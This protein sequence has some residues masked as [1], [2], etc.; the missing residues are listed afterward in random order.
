VSRYTDALNAREVLEYVVVD[1]IELSHL[2]VRAQRDSWQ[3][4]C[5]SWLLANPDDGG[6][7]RRVIERIAADPAVEGRA[8]EQRDRW[9]RWC[10][11]SLVAHPVPDLEP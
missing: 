1:C 4:T 10:A 5:R 2:Q 11:Q 9:R 3:R 6:G 7:L 8:T